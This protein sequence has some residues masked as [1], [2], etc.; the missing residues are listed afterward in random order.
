MKKNYFKPE[1][2]KKELLVQNLLGDTSLEGDSAGVGSGESN[3]E[4]LSKSNA[5]W[6]D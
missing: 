4:G 1:V 2:E 3:D 5:I 6:E